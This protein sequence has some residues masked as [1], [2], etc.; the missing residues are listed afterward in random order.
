[1]LSTIVVLSTMSSICPSGV[2]KMGFVNEYFPF[3]YY[4]G[5]RPRGLSLSLWTIIAKSFNCSSVELIE[6]MN[7][8]SETAMDTPGWEL[9]DQ[10]NLGAIKKSDIFVDLTLNTLSP[11]RF[12]EFRRFTID[13]AI[14]QLSLFEAV[15][16]TSGE[17]WTP[18]D[19]FLVFPP[20]VLVLIIVFSILMNLTNV[21]NNRLKS[22]LGLC[23][24]YLVV[25]LFSIAIMT[26]F[27]LHGAVFKGNMIVT[28]SPV[29]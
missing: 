20:P 22:L 25:M 10:G 19:F 26:L 9:A 17:S 4:D 23:F 16:R 6:Y 13:L 12:G 21:A 14:D 5:K 7:Y 1:E 29:L 8:T 2:L 24:R 15:N 11:L 18:Y 27:F 28:A 3:F